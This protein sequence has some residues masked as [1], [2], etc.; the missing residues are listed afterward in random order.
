MW[1]TIVFFW[2]FLQQSHVPKKILIASVLIFFSF[3]LH[4]A[5]I[6]RVK[7]DQAVVWCIYVF[8]FGEEDFVRVNFYQH[9]YGARHILVQSNDLLPATITNLIDLLIWFLQFYLWLRK[10]DQGR[11]WSFRQF[12]NRDIERLLFGHRITRVKVL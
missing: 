1:K 7:N 12:Q 3:Q 2:I 10:L 4:S 9:L 8:D 5:Q 6:D 11:R